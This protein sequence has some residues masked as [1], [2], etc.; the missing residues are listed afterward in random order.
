MYKKCHAEGELEIYS[1]SCVNYAD[2][3]YISL[4]EKDENGHRKTEIRGN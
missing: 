3:E 1:N 4:C 2:I